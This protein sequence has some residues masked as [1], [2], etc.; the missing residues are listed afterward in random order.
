MSRRRHG[1]ASASARAAS[2]VAIAS[3]TD[4]RSPVTEPGTGNTMGET[5]ERD[6]AIPVLDEL[7]ELRRRQKQIEDFQARAAGM[8]SGVDADVYA[9]VTK[10]YAARHQA[11]ANQAAPLKVQ[12]RQEYARLLAVYGDIDRRH[13][14]ARLAKE[15]I[16][17]RHALGEL[18]DDQRAE[19]GREPEQILQDCDAERARCDRQRA[20]FQEALTEEELNQVS[21]VTA[22]A[23]P[24]QEETPSATI[25]GPAP[26]APPPV[27]A[28]DA[29]FLGPIEDLLAAAPE[30]ALDDRTIIAPADALPSEV[31]EDPTNRAPLVIDAVLVLEE[32]N[33]PRIEFPLGSLD[34]IGRSE[35]NQ[36]R[37]VRPGVSRRHALIRRDGSA[38]VLQDLNSQNGTFLNGN[39]ISE[40]VL[41]HGDRIWVGDVELLFSVPGS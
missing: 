8:Q 38:Y 39:R 7:I 23:A 40:E 17:F 18:T 37:L 28:D 15:E 30:P 19:R 10:D 4:G 36:V 12:A 3:E 32:P 31:L 35:D 27:P 11:L 13:H 1:T 34:Q 14:D 21:P 2:H 16:E 9:R 6:A 25:P 33:V 24:A 26:A 41:H 5:Q 20:R 22:A 29:T